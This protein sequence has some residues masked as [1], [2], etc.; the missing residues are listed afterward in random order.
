MIGGM[1]RRAR[2]PR[3]RA[4]GK[5]GGGGRHRPGDHCGVEI[6][7]P[8]PWAEK[9]G[10][11]YRRIMDTRDRASGPDI[12]PIGLG[13]V[14]VDSLPATLLTEKA[15][16]KYTV[17]AVFTRRPEREEWT[18]SSSAQGFTRGRK[19]PIRSSGSQQNGNS[20]GHR[21]SP[22]LLGPWHSWFLHSALRVQVRQEKASELQP[23][24]AKSATGTTKEAMSADDLSFFRHLTGQARCTG[25]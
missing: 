18:R 7:P 10:T 2:D 23:T 25:R 4:P 15:P 8:E 11:A 17:A 6:R 12:E 13:S 16:A 24:S 3:R 22:R 20:D 5:P 1:R 19:P 9:T 14:L 21:R